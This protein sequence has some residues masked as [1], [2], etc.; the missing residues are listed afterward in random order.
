MRV[1][2]SV[3]KEFKLYA[4]TDIQQ[5]NLDVLDRIDA[6]YRGGADIVQLRSKTVSDSELYY[7][8]LK[9]REIA[10]RYAKL[11]FVND[12]VDLACAVAA[13]GVH[14]G[15]EDLPLARVKEICIRA[16][17]HLWIGKSTHSLEQALSAE[18]EGADYIGV[19]PVFA[20]PTKAHYPAVGTGLVSEVAKA[21]KIPF[22]PIG[23]I[24]EQNMESVLKAGARRVAFVRAIFQN[25]SVYEATKRLREK[26]EKFS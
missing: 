26:I 21:V 23:G 3:F 25:R 4:V 8:G 17:Q 24:N 14:L 9:I 22:V 5:V 16:G 10:D 13:D 19:G 12:R 11:F 15:Q 2:D 20:T 6:A 1:K 18:K 7:L